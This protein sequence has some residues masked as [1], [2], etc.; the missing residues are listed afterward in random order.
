MFNLFNSWQYFRVLDLGYSINKTKGG[1][2]WF[3]VLVSPSEIIFWGC[4]LGFSKIHIKN[5]VFFVALCEINLVLGDG[6]F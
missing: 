2:R 1:G 4:G 5:F 6:S 3:R